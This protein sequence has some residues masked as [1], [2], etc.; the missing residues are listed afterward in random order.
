MSLCSSCLGF[1]LTSRS[2]L[3][4]PSIDALRTSASTCPLCHL[5]LG[6]LENS[7]QIKWAEEYRCHRDGKYLLA[8]DTSIIISSNVHGPMPNDKKL[9]P[10]WRL[11]V[12]CGPL[13]REKARM[14]GA[15]EFTP[16]NTETLGIYAREGT[17]AAEVIATRP[18]TR[19]FTG[20]GRFAMMKSW[21]TSCA[22]GHDKCQ[23]GYSREVCGFGAY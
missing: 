12:S 6:V 9:L 10:P 4:Q 7:N 13:Q 20:D 19:E 21:V 11:V 14:T 15:D 5:I 3:L 23:L 16:V 22:E 1:T 2:Y 8:N 18:L 17:P